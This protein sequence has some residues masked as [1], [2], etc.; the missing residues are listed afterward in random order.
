MCKL[1][2]FSKTLAKSAV[3]LFQVPKP[4]VKTRLQES[5]MQSTPDDTASEAGASDILQQ[6]GA[7]DHFTP[8]EHFVPGPDTELIIN[9]PRSPQR[10][11][12]RAPRDPPDVADVLTQ[13]TAVLA[14]MMADLCHNRQAQPAR[15]QQ[16]D[17]A[18]PP[19]DPHFMWKRLALP[20][21][22]N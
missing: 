15:P 5:T 20:S 16:H 1:V 2:V 8:P 6:P 19:E 18:D 21:E 13:Q 4:M 10:P 22:T 17:P 11:R 9:A 7:E 14:E 3:Q 12:P